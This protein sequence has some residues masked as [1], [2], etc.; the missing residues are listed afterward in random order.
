M[1]THGM[2]V[3][4]SNWLGPYLVGSSLFLFTLL[5]RRAT[6]HR[7]MN[8]ALRNHVKNKFHKHLRIS[9]ITKYICDASPKG[10]TVVQI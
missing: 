2:L 9:Y 3:G 5:F 8:V 6:N 4:L 7:Y 10:V 1:A